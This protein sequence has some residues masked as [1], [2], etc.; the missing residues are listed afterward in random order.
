MISDCNLVRS[1]T[2][3]S[4]L[5]RVHQ[6]KLE[7]QEPR[8]VQD[9]LGESVYRETRDHKERLENRFTMSFSYMLSV[10][11]DSLDC[12]GQKVSRFRAKRTKAPSSAC[13]DESSS[14]GRKPDTTL[15]H[16]A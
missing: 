7:L 13:L 2:W 5:L 4:F 10:E 1:E 8:E 6:E 3:T 16:L 9:L 15:H 12:V 11:A 14:G